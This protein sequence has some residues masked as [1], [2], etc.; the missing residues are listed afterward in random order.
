MGLRYDQV[1]IQPL[2]HPEN[3]KQVS[4][5]ATTIMVKQGKQGKA[6]PRD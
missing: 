6:N 3:L 5:A 1:H 2:R 4:L